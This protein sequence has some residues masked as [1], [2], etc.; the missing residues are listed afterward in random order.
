VKENPSKKP[1]WRDIL[2]DP[3]VALVIGGRGQ[4]KTALAHRLLETWHEGTSRSAHIIGFPEE[5]LGLLPDWINP[6]P[7]IIP[8]E[9]WPQHSVVLAH[10]AH[11]FLHARRSMKSENLNMDMLVSI[12]RHKDS[13]IIFETQQTP[14]LDRN[15][16]M[17]V[18][19]VIHRY[20][21]LL[22]EEFERSQVRKLTRRAKECLDRY[23]SVSE[24]EGY[25][26]MEE[27]PELLK[28]AWVYSNRF[29][30]EYPH[31]IELPGYWSEDISR[32][33][34]DFSEIEREVL[35]Q[36]ERE[37]LGNILEL[38]ESGDYNEELGWEYGDVRALNGGL[39]AKFLNEG[40]IERGLT[41]NNTKC[42][43]GNLEKIR[44]R[45]GAE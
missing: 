21:Q 7:L 26:Y 30:G 2:R 23:V 25:V 18:D 22:Q 6:L 32:A 36:K 42:F 15:A 5:K 35:S 17:A 31:E 10:E 3:W 29:V 20:P 1:D 8:K 16:P 44:E 33:Y 27:S 9:Q 28:H 37:A 4:G 19:A 41:T 40:L 45:L 38:E 34:G 12:S 14:R 11:H 43:F 13:D 24:E 39:I